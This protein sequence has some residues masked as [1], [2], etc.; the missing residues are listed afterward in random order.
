MNKVVPVALRE[1]IATVK[2]KAFVLSVVLC[3]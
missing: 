2:T 1:F 3:R